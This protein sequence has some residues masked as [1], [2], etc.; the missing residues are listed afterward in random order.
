M[1]LIG[2]Y[3]LYLP[4]GEWTHKN[5]RL[6]IITPG[7]TNPKPIAVTTKWRHKISEI[8]SLL[9]TVSSQRQSYP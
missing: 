2:I 6:K 7:V 3:I 5:E 1:I 9:P 4:G 8:I